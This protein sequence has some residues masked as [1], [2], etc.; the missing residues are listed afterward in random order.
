MKS[1]GAP[2]VV[3]GRDGL[4]LVIEVEAELDDLR[5]AVDARGRYRLEGVDSDLRIVEGVPVAYIQV[6]RPLAVAEE[7]APVR[8]RESEAPVSG[9]RAPRTIV[10]V[11]NMALEDG[12]DDRLIE[13]I[14]HSPGKGRRAFDRYDRADD[15]PPLCAEVSKLRIY[16]KTGARALSLATGLATG[17]GICNGSAMMQVEA[18]GVEPGSGN[19]SMRATTRVSGRLF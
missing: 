11:A 18:P 5:R 2:E 8:A 1:R 15:W 14:T 4:P 9:L 10:E 17:G 16:P 7:P 19:G 6:T 12:V 3:Y 13:R